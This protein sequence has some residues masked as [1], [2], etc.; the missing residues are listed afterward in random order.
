MR[1]KLARVLGR[2]PPYRRL[3]QMQAEGMAYSL[4]RRR[5]ERKV[6]GTKPIFTR[7]LDGHGAAPCEV[8]VLTYA[9]DWLMALW[10]AKSFYSSAGVDW[11]LIWHQGG[12][13]SARHV[14][15]LHYHFPNSGFLSMAEADARVEPALQ[16][17]GLDRTVAV[18][19]TS[20]F[21]R[22][23]IDFHL[24]SRSSKVLLLDSDVLF[25]RKPTEILDA[26][27]AGSRTNYFNKDANNGYPMTPKEAQNRFGLRPVELLNAGLGVVCRESI[28]LQEVNRYLQDPEMKGIFMDQLVYALLG[29]TFPTELLPDTYLLSAT[30]GLNVGGRPVV[31][32][33]YAGTTRRLMFTEGIPRL[34]DQGF[35]REL[36][37]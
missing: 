27:H 12:P 28:K 36:Q 18:R 2:F 16:Q 31:A 20:A 26:V 9:A 22:K 1:Q 25:F 33:H 11:P 21:L 5:L 14:R 34:I 8:R 29:A 4:R 23:P 17:L 35:L 32:R 24:L 6:L 3:R 30:P 15:L 10:M 37:P 7:P 13:L 19:R